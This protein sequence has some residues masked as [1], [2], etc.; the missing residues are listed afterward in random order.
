MCRIHPSVLQQTR[1]IARLQ[2]QSCMNLS[3]MNLITPTQVDLDPV[4][5]AQAYDSSSIHMLL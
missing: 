4:L 1:Q 5:P 2:Q 3:C